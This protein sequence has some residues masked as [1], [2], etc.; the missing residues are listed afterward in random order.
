VKRAVA[1]VMIVL[2]AGGAAM[3][4]PMGREESFVAKEVAKIT[5]EEKSRELASVTIGD[6]QTW[7]D[8]LSAA[9][10][11][12]AY[13]MR[14]GGESFVLPGLGQFKNK[15]AGLGALFL[16]SHLAVGVGSLLGSYFLL[17]ANLRLDGLDYFNT[18]VGT[19]EG[20][21][22]AHTLLDYLPSIGVAMAGHLI[23]LGIRALAAHNARAIALQRVE[24]GAV[25]PAADRW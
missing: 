21:W 20:T 25:T 2:V 4:R 8:R 18:P 13:I 10:R 22:K 7:K 14:S 23:D 9:A 16:G 24:S 19:I 1:V 11:K 6:L 5:E 15:Q 3:A 17:P 12:D